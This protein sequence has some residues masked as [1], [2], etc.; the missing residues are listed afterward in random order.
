M[1]DL[2]DQVREHYGMP[3]LERGMRV[4][5]DGAERVVLDG[6]PSSMEIVAV[7]HTLE[8]IGPTIYGKPVSQF[9]PDQIDRLM[10]KKS[11]RPDCEAT[12]YDQNGMLLMEY[13]RAGRVPLFRMPQMY[14]PVLHIDQEEYRVFLRAQGMTDI[15]IDRLRV[16]LFYPWGSVTDDDPTHARLGRNHPYGILLYIK[17]GLLADTLAR[18]M[19]HMLLWSTHYFMQFVRGVPQEG[20]QYAAKANA[21]AFDFALR[22]ANRRFITGKPDCIVPAPA[23]LH[24]FV[25]EELAKEE[26]SGRLIVLTPDLLHNW[27]TTPFWGDG[28]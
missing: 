16:D 9:P 20:H 27:W 26:Q 15:Q 2:L 3:W 10:G 8:K 7:C 24:E 6:D 25:L 19:N 23:W 21:D 28:K 14:T 11:F 22:H 17:P 18:E 13:K 12:Y 1:T 5:I 4:N